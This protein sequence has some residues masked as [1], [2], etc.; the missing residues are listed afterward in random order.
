MPLRRAWVLAGFAAALSCNRLPPGAVAVGTLSVSEGNLARVP[1][2]AI[3]A[4][5]VRREMKAALERTRHFAVREG[6]SARV[7]LDL[8]SARRLAGGEGAVADVQ[9]V[10]E[11]TAASPEGDPER[12]VSEGAGRAASAADA[13]TEAAVR[14]AAFEGALRGALDDAARGLAW[15]LESRRKTDDELSRDLVDVDPRVR[16]YAIRT[17]ADRRSPAVVPQL[18]ARLEDDNPAVALRAVGAL[19]AI[20]DRRAVEPLIEMTRK[21]PPQ[22]V[23]QVLYAL[24]SL[25]GPT[26]EAFLYTLESG[27]PDDEVRHAATDALVELRRKREEASARDVHPPRP[28]SH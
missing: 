3:P 16:D 15:Q 8:E 5:Q 24:A 21:R 4:E 2:L 1:E 20:G 27:A 25:G 22:L 26:A 10:L 17:L 12:T 11:L 28:R 19:V 14:L 18:I 7:R 13:G 6:A 9:L 23:A